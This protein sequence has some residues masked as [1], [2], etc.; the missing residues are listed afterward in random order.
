MILDRFHYYL[1]LACI[2]VPLGGCAVKHQELELIHKDAYQ[3]YN[4]GDYMTAVEKFEI[5]VQEIPKDDEL[6]FRLGNAYGRSGMPQRAIEAYQNSLMRNPRLGKAWYNMGILQM[7]MALKSFSDMETF[8][9]QNDPL[10]KENIRLREGL[11]S[12]L[13]PEADEEQKE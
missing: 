3:A 4:A 12:L 9:D 7:N 11:Y 8:V 13:Y 5:L 2:L 10:M 6:W 1:L